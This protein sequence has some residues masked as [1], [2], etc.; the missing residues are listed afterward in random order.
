MVS[1]FKCECHGHLRIT[2]EIAREHNY[3]LLPVD[4]AHPEAVPEVNKDML[5]VLVIITPGKNDD[6]YWKNEHLKKQLEEKAIPLFNILHPN[7][8]ALF[9]FDNSSNHGRYAPDAL[10]VKNLNVSDGGAKC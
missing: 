2:E 4:P 7:C 6:G 8:Q 10:R 9:A 5:H 3:G 1:D